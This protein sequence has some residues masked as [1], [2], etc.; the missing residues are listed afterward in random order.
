[1]AMLVRATTTSNAQGRRQRL[2]LPSTLKSNELDADYLH[3]LKV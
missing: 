1:M 2:H 3:A